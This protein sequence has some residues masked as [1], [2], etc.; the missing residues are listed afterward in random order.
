MCMCVWAMSKQYYRYELVRGRT[1]IKRES[2][3]A[4]RMIYLLVPFGYEHLRDAFL[5]LNF[6]RQ[7]CD[8]TSHEPYHK[9]A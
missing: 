4:T 6:K 2:I 5:S 3:L 1:E 8:T 7:V 9:P